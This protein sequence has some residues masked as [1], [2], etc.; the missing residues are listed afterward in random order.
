MTHPFRILLG[1]I[2]TLTYCAASQAGEGVNGLLLPG[3]KAAQA[4]EATASKDGKTITF[5]GEEYLLKNNQS[6]PGQST[7]ELREYLR[8]GED[9]D[10]YRKMV[11][12]R[13]MSKE[14]KAEASALANTILEQTKKQYPGSYTK[15]IF[16]EP[17]HA[18]ILY[19]V[20]SGENVEFNFWD[21]RRTPEGYPSVQFV[22]RNKAPYET[23][24]KFKAEQDARYDTW[25]ADLATL[26]DRA[27]KILAATS[28]AAPS[29]K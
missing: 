10:G 15:E 4:A 24:A 19:I 29:G 12:L 20:V 9:W 2:L 1:L 21:F 7:S 13:M 25:M 28:G 16:A 17:D 8:E 11:A 26:C 27:E 3:K 18:V 6:S 22:L 5:D 14:I 23:A